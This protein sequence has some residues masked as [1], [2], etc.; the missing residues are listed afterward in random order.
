M[1]PDSKLPCNVTVIKTIQGLVFPSVGP[2]TEGLMV[3][4]EVLLPVPY[5]QTILKQQ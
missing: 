4:S 2:W 3:G 5:V 1:L